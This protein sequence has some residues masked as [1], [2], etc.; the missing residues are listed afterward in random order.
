MYSINDWINEPLKYSV[1]VTMVATE[2]FGNSQ[3]QQI[4]HNQ[5]VSLH[6]VGWSSVDYDLVHWAIKDVRPLRCRK[7]LL[8]RKISKSHL[9]NSELCLDIITLTC[10]Y[11]K[12]NLMRVSLKPRVYLCEEI[13]FILLKTIYLLT[14]FLFSKTL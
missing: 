6:S 11:W 8:W 10:H 14:V 3:E 12:L 5:N 9:Q 7:I 4:N 2:S 1:W 13:C